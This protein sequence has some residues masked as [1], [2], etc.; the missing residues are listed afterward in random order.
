MSEGDFFR[1]IGELKKS[2]NDPAQLKLVHAVE[3]VGKSLLKG[4]TNERIVRKLVQALFVSGNVIEDMENNDLFSAE[5]QAAHA[6]LA[7][8]YESKKHL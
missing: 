2:V 4:R 1:A 5:L 3:N 8:Y 7:A 6:A